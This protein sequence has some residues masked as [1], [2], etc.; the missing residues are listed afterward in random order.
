MAMIVAIKPNADSRIVERE[1]IGRGLWI[2]RFDAEGRT[3]F[4]IAAHSAHVDERELLAIAGVESVAVR[5][6]A[7]PR[8]M[9]QAAVISIQGTRIGASCPPVVIA[10]PCSVESELQI[11]AI[12]ER[13]SALG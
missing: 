11:F 13:L 5:K 4:S 8:V 1:L 9:K 6:Q 12:A 10:G 7:H 2:E 3:Y